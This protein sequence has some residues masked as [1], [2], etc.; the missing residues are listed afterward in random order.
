MPNGGTCLGFTF[1][2]ALLDVSIVDCDARGWPGEI[3]WGSFVLVLC[4][5]SGSNLLNW[6]SWFGGQPTKLQ[7]ILGH[8]FDVHARW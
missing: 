3:W 8:E 4:A 5:F 2:P 7:G 1:P 6:C